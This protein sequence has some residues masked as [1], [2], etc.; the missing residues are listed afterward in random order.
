MSAPRMAHQDRKLVVRNVLRP[1]GA[2]GFPSDPVFFG[3]SGQLIITLTDMLRSKQS[4]FSL[5]VCR[6]NQYLRNKDFAL[7]DS[8]G[9]DK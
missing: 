7:I 8:S 1:M 9:K 5:T 3:K 4:F 2:E 6:L